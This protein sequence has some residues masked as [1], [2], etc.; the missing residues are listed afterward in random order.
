MNRSKLFALT[1]ILTIFTS[2]IPAWSSPNFSS[3]EN[4]IILPTTAFEFLSSNSRDVGRT[5]SVYSDF[6]PHWTTEDGFSTLIYVRNVQM[7]NPVSVSLSL[8]VGN[9]TVALAERQIAPAQTKRI[10]VRQELIANGE[11]GEQQGSAVITFTANSSGG[12]NAYTQV[13]NEAQSLSFSFPFMRNSATQEGSLDAVAWY[14]DHDTDV[15]SAVQNT[16]NNPVVVIPTLFVDGQSQT[17]EPKQLRPNESASIKLPDLDELNPSPQSRSIGVRISHNGGAGAVVAQGWAINSQRGFSTAFAFH[18]QGTCACRSGEARHLYGTGVAIGTGGMMSPT[19]TFEPYL[20]LRNNS[21]SPMS[22]KP[23]FKYHENGNLRRVQLPRINLASQ[24]TTLKNL[25]RYQLDG[26]IPS[27]VTDGDIDIE[28]ESDNGSLIGELASVDTNGTFV[29]GVPLICSGNRALHAAY[30]RTD[31]DWDSMLTFENIANQQNNVE[32][33]I[34]YSGGLYTMDKTLSA[35]ETGMISVKELQHN[36]TPDRNGNVIP[37]TATVGGMNIWSNNVNDGLVINAM[38]VNPVTRTC[39]Y[40]GA[41]GY[42]TD[43]GL[44]DISGSHCTVGFN[45]YEYDDS[46]QVYMCLYFSTNQ[47]GTDT[48]TNL[49]TS[50]SDILQLIDSTSFQVVGVGTGAFSAQTQGVWPEDELTCD[51]GGG[52]QISDVGN[53]EAKPKIKIL[54]DGQE[55]TTTQNVVVGERI[56]LSATV[57]GGGTPSSKQW[58]IAGDKV[59]DYLIVCDGSP[60]PNGGTICQNPTS[61]EAPEPTGLDQSEVTCY[62]WKGGNNLQVEYKVT[63]GGRQYPKSVT[64]NVLSPTGAITAVQGATTTRGPIFTEQSSGNWYLT[65]GDVFDPGIRLRPN[66]TYPSGVS[67]TIQ[68]IQTYSINRRYKNLD[69]T[70]VKVLGTGIDFTYPYPFVGPQTQDMVD[71]PR[72]QLTGVVQGQTT[73]NWQRVEVNDSAKTWLMFKPNTNKSIWVPLSFVNW[74]WSAVALKEG[75]NWVVD[76][77]S[78][79]GPTAGSPLAFPTWTGNVKFIPYQPE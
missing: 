8:M 47:S 29:S 56:K 26:T 42:V 41:F 33:T 15:Y 43:K 62:W 34:S 28:Y 25:R 57:M 12:I 66:M 39:G 1:L 60:G 52:R 64:F 23:I 51:S 10:N 76:T 50:T 46:F 40:C 18:H 55:I 4:T 27:S 3:I 72:Q 9:R 16:T 79:T 73:F 71:N 17:L 36:H 38:V 14:Y 6:L 59:G 44:T 13:I 31:G 49:Q 35:N 53:I 74:S 7:E 24:K 75:S 30:W 2:V 19:A 65:H 69:N 5:N 37:T 48:I 70:W 67:G 61:A 58:T 22:V 63:I 20:A 77:S 78:K 45:E 32:I 68:W 54:R 11:N 21:N